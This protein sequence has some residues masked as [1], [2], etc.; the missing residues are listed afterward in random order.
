MHY[1]IGHIQEAGFKLVILKDEQSGSEVALL[2]QFGALIHAF[3]I[4]TNEGLFNVIDHYENLDRLQKELPGS[5]KGSKLSPFPCRIP[6]GKYSFDGK[7]Y[8]FGNKFMD[9]S[10]IHGLLYDKPF[11]VTHETAGKDSA[12]V[13]M[14]YRYRQDDPQY[15]FDYTCRVVYTL[16][17]D[18]LLQVQTILV[19]EGRSVMPI[20]DGWHPYFRL[21]GKLDEWML[22]F[23]AS[24][25]VE[26]D[27]RLVPTGKLLDYDL[28]NLPAKIG[29]TELD[30][31]FLLNI[32]SGYPACELF[33]PNNK[34]KISFFPDSSY[35]YLQ[36]Y[37][38]PHRES[39][40]IENLSSAP[41]SFNNK[42]GLTLLQPAAPQTFTVQYQLS[43]L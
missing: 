26:F 14:E 15:P 39:I 1:S 13:S 38:P 12:T 17:P 23:G 35:P 31:C 24:A 20:A 11:T 3:R 8:E 7:H 32:E 41:D 9:G 6:E 29:K 42:M 27:E 40:A 18:A 25:M 30:N 34:L 19:N 5:F 43:L 10:A 16:F 36:V 28:F 21:G 37:T 2:P 33:N 22:H 4:K